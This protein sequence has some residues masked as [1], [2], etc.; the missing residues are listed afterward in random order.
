MEL[1]CGL[2]FLEEDGVHVNQH[3]HHIYD[4]TQHFI[5]ESPTTTSPECSTSHLQ[6]IFIATVTLEFYNKRKQVYTCQR[7]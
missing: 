1:L 3:S 5:T 6:L 7:K 4:H 2:L